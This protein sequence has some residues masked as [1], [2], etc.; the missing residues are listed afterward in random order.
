MFV[1]Y[2]IHF[3]YDSA[4]NLPKGIPDP[5]NPYPEHAKDIVVTTLQFSAHT[6]A[7]QTQALILQ[8]LVLKSKDIL[9]APQSKQVRRY[10]YNRW[11]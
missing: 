8:K 11:R 1:D 2:T 4:M 5:D 7:A 9:G 10:C 6:S 3:I